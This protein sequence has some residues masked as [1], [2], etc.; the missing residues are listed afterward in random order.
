VPASRASAVGKVYSSW[1]SGSVVGV[2]VR[3]SE[4]LDFSVCE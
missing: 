2:M 4:Q 1:F 3:L